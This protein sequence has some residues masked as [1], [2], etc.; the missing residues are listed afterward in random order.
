MQVV[1]ITLVPHFLIDSHGCYFPSTVENFILICTKE[2]TTPNLFR[3]GLP[4][5]K[6]NEKGEF[7]Q[8]NF[9]IIVLTI[10]CLRR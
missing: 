8:I 1:F 6:L 2:T 4:N 9:T 7:T 5:N 10:I 3:E